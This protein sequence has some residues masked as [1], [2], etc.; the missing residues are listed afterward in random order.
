M[1]LPDNQSHEAQ[2]RRARTRAKKRETIRLE[3]L[4]IAQRMISNDG[5]K[6]TR[7]REI[8]RRAGISYQTLYNYFPAK[9]LILETL[10]NT[11]L[12]ESPTPESIMLSPPS[13]LAS[14]V[15]ARAG[16]VGA[17]T[18]RG[19]SSANTDPED[20]CATMRETIEQ[21]FETASRSQSRLLWREVV[22]D[23]L[24]QQSDED[25]RVFR[26]LN[27]N[28]PENV[29]H[30]ARGTCAAGTLRPPGS[31]DTFAALL[32]RLI[33]ASLLAY[34]LQPALSRREALQALSEQVDVILQ[35]YSNEEAPAAA[36]EPQ[37]RN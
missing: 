28:G 20:F 15:S 23:R 24:Q 6:Q 8:A 36:M 33:D 18:E 12:H 2:A 35:P 34:L 16:L 9:S 37:W 1:S 4:R 10:L 11:N 31:A 30:C 13:Q 21:A 29:Y 32:C 3:I 27:P 17:P 7:M 19:N 26:S 25:F 14:M 22:L 5:Y